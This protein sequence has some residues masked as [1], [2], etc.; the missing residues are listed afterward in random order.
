MYPFISR[1][2]FQEPDLSKM[3]AQTMLPV[4]KYPTTFFSE[5]LHTILRSIII[6]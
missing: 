1:S 2:Y 5:P 3:V 4:S 6:I